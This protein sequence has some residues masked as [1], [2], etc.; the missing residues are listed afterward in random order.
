M[1]RNIRDRAKVLLPYLLYDESPY[2]VIRDDGELV[3]VL[4]AYTVSNSYP[5]SQKTTIQVEGK[6]KQINYIRNLNIICNIV[7]LKTS[8]NHIRHYIYV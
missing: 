8:S 4:D 6:Y 3:W 7:F 5:Y 2:M 1:N